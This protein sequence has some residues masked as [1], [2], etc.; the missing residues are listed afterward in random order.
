M[1]CQLKSKQK[2]RC[3]SRLGVVSSGCI[4]NKERLGYESAGISPKG[5]QFYLDKQ[6]KQPTDFITYYGM[7]QY[8]GIDDYSIYKIIISADQ[9]ATEVAKAMADGSKVFQ[10]VPFGS[11][12]NDGDF[13][14]KL[15]DTINQLASS[16]C[17][18][19]IFLDECEVGYWD[20]SYY[21]NPEK[22]KVF[23]EGL[24]EATSY[25]SSVG[26]ES[27]VNGVAAYADIGTYYMWESF[28]GTWDTN[29]IYWQGD[30]NGRRVKN[31]ND[32][33]N[34]FY[35]WS[36]WTITGDIY[37]NNEGNI[38]SRGSGNGMMSIEYDINDLIQEPYTDVTDFVY[39]EWFGG[40]A[41]DE[42]LEIYAF[43]GNSL[44]YSKETWEE[45]PK[46]WKG[47]PGSWNGINKSAKCV[48]IELRFKGVK[49]L[50]MTQSFM[51]YGYVYPI[52]NMSTPNPPADQNPELWNYNLEKWRY[53]KS[54]GS[55]DLCHSYGT[56]TDENKMAY[57]FT[58]FKVL[59]GYAWDY[60]HPLHQIIK[61]TDVLDDPFGCMLKST[62]LK[63]G[64]FHGVFS[65]L[66]C[67]VDMN[68]GKYTLSRYANPNYWFDRGISSFSPEHSIYKNDKQY[69]THVFGFTETVGEYDPLP[70]GEII[71]VWGPYYQYEL[72]YDALGN[73]IG[74]HIQREDASGNPIEYTKTV[75]FKKFMPPA[76]NVREVYCYDD[77][78]YFYFAIKV[79]G[80][81][82][83]LLEEKLLNKYYIYI[84]AEGLDYGFKGQWFGLPYKSQFMIYNQSLFKWNKYADDETDY[85]QFEYIGNTFLEYEFQNA[86]RSFIRYR[87]KKSVL[88]EASRLN[89]HF[90]IVVETP[91]NLVCI[92]PENYD[93]TVDPVAISSVVDYRQRRYDLYCPHGYVR[94]DECDLGGYGFIFNFEKYEPQ[95][96][97]VRVFVRYKVLGSDEWS[98]Y[99]FVKQTGYMLYMPCERMQWVCSLNTVDGK[100]TPNVTN[101]KVSRIQVLPEESDVVTDIGGKVL[102]GFV[103][104]SL[105]EYVTELTDD[106]G[107][108]HSHDIV[109]LNTFVSGIQF[110]DYSGI[111]IGGK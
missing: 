55:R 52:Y 5:N 61:Y 67:D 11:R 26:L 19:G 103:S 36:D 60:T 73:V 62:E 108:I 74:S 105:I 76:C 12:F 96:T 109:T 32:T 37:V 57:T 85:T 69:S 63:S 27:I 54:V 14:T 34:Y 95:N 45:L 72:E 7:L 94:S 42:T 17:A 22:C 102:I 77:I 4:F 3:I 106:I 87:I 18:D 31:A 70:E 86:D 83:L 13:L 53:L 56:I 20:L 21:D 100:V 107:T 66:E 16:G 81:I 8:S 92:C 101:V 97:N 91:D 71:E 75:A 2:A 88:G 9:T 51:A 46:L 111:E 43:V 41:N 99:T 50:N 28:V 6:Y 44:P 58:C 29:K 78:F 59:D 47:E 80:E 104:T 15:K 82:N 39:F 65:G 49:N 23:R 40:G 110:I 35:N 48:R 38:T 10:Y 25:C 84:S 30:G 90:T 33:V 1:K 89:M 79:Q 64:V 98:D 24:I 68:L 93:T